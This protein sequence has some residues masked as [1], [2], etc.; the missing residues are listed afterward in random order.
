VVAAVTAV[1]GGKF[2]DSAP[3][4]RSLMEIDI[5]QEMTGKWLFVVE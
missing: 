2:S 3:T 1:E 4:M 5:S